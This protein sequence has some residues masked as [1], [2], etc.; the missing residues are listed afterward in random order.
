MC[1][2]YVKQIKGFVEGGLDEHEN[3]Y[4][5]VPI[6][7]FQAARGNRKYNCA[8][9]EYFGEVVCFFFKFTYMQL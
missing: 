4:F 8:F 9:S 6:Q 1:T 2:N 5:T 7:N 3:I